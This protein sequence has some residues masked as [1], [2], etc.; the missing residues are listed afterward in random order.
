MIVIKALLTYL[1][2]YLVW[3][4]FLMV[5]ETSR[6]KGEEYLCDRWDI[7]KYYMGSGN[8][9]FGTNRVRGATKDATGGKSFVTIHGNGSHSNQRG[10]YEYLGK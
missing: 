1:L 5:W 2:T 3:K 9:H 7:C 8:G 6:V 10:S 4:T